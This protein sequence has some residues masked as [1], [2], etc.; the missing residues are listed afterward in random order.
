MTGICG[1]GGKADCENSTVFFQIQCCES[2]GSEN[3][4]N[5]EIDHT[6]YG[7]SAECNSNK[8]A[9]GACGSG[10]FADCKSTG[11]TDYNELFCCDNDSIGYGDG[12]FLTQYGS[13]GEQIYCPPGYAVSRFC[14]S[15][16]GKDCS[17]NSVTKIQCQP[18]NVLA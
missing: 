18:Y 10:Q 1:S 16:R 2:G 3:Q 15:G 14:G 8:L 11:S 13:Y 12:E 5:C 4:K 7:K 9:Y 17:S 6:K